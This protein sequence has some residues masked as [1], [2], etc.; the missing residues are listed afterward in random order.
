[1]L[2]LVLNGK[3]LSLIWSKKNILI[4]PETLH[5]DPRPKPKPKP[6]PSRPGGGGV[7]LGAILSLS[8]L[9]KVK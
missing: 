3:T 8:R 4:G 5:Q 1:M 7:R 2:F 6:T 9:N